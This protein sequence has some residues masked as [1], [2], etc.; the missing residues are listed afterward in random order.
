MESTIIDVPVA[1]LVID[2]PISEKN[3]EQKI[4]S[5]EANGLVQP[6]TVWLQDMRIIDGFHRVEAAKRLDWRTITCNV[7]DCDEEAFWDARIM[8]AKQHQDIDQERLFT[9]ISNCWQ[10]TPWAKTFAHSKSTGNTTT[11]ALIGLAKAI[12]DLELRF[13]QSYRHTFLSNW[14][15]KRLGR[16][17]Q[18]SDE[19][20]HILQW[21]GEKIV[22]WGISYWDFE[23]V[24]FEHFGDTPDGKKAIML[25]EIAKKRQMPLADRL[26]L[27][28][29][30]AG[31]RL[32][33]IGNPARATQE[34]LIEDWLNEI[35]EGEMPQES[36]ASY[37]A[38]IYEENAERAKR[39][40]IKRE[41]EAEAERK[42]PF[43]IRRI[44]LSYADRLSSYTNNHKTALGTVPEGYEILMGIA[45]WCIQTCTEIWPDLNHIE[46]EANPLAVENL[47]LRKQLAEEHDARI[48]A[49]ADLLEKKERAAKLAER[50]PEVMA[51][52][53]VDIV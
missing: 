4:A 6:I 25:D 44:L 22:K 30:L 18:L 45:E 46:A 16:E 47:R 14:K 19:Q 34:K 21:I 32:G 12:W 35:P 49:E 10:A 11:D 9:W 40:R 37:V 8:S 33:P 39:E 52:S 27:S 43:V 26:I 53:E 7:I 42:S 20:W 41:E 31:S 17:L 13:P 2:L 1:E 24:I 29:E 15:R 38:Q 50:L 3:V 48:R 36:L 28:K 5:L 51:W 23:I